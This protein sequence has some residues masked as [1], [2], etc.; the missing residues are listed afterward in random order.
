MERCRHEKFRGEGQCAAEGRYRNPD[1]CYRPD[2][3][4]LDTFASFMRAARWCAAHKNSGGRPLESKGGE[5]PEQ[6]AGPAGGESAR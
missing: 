3:P 2:R 4:G 1:Y 5:T 6:D